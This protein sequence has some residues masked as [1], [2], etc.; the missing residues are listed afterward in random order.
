M[1]TQFNY[2][3]DW[4]NFSIGF[5]IYKSILK[6]WK[7]GISVDITF[8][9]IWINFGEQKPKKESNYRIQIEQRN[10]G[11]LLYIPQ[12]KHKRQWYNLIDDDDTSFVFLKKSIAHCFLYFN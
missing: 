2:L 9:S 4:E 6:E 12:A 1:K 7:I 5:S 3:W 8:F 11:E 10:N